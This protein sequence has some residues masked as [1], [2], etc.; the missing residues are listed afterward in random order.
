MPCLVLLLALAFPRVILILM[1]LF[2]HMLDTAYHGLVIPL[3]GFFLMPITT[4]A[5]AWVVSTGRPIDGI[6]LILIIVAVV[7]DLSSH[8]GS[9]RYRQVRN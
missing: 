6:N 8:G 1:W 5:Y 9:Y 7:L 2:T 4:I 3:I